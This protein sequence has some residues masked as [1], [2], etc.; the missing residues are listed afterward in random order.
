MLT[1]PQLVSI[2]NESPHTYEAI[3]Q[4]VTAVNSIG[5]ATGVDPSG[6]IAPPDP[7]GGISVVAA[8]GIFDIAITDNSAVYRGIYYFAESDTSPDFTAPH[9]YFLGSSRNLRVSLGNQT[10]YW[11]GYS[12]YL[13]S[14]PSAPVVFGAPP[15]GVI[16]GGAA[17]PPL[18]ASSGSGTAAGQSGGSGFG[19][20][21]VAG[22][23]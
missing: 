22:S 9:V 13:G 23:S 12:Q 3:R 19:K 8:D 7:I 20:V 15:T 1:L 5:R 21:T 18:Q 10:L 2:K 16:G 17:G 4:L 14:Q 6:S 11:R